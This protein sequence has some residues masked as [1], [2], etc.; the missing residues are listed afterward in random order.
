MALRQVL[1]FILLACSAAIIVYLA[2]FYDWQAGGTSGSQQTVPEPY[3]DRDWSKSDNNAQNIS[4]FVF[5]D[6][7]RN[8][9]YDVGDPPMA[10]VTVELTRPDGSTRRHAS[11]INGYTNFSMHDGSDNHDITTVD[12][13]YRFDLLIPPG[14]KVT[15]TNQRQYTVFTRRQGSA[16]GIVAAS[17]PTVIGL[18]PDLY[19]QSRIKNYQPHSHSLLAT[20]PQGDSTEVVISQSGSFSHPAYPGEWLLTLRKTNNPG[21]LEQRVSV[22]ETPVIL[23]DFDGT[24]KQPSPNNRVVVQDFEYQNRS[25]IDKIPMG[26]LGLGWDFL[27]A[28]DNQFYNGPGYVNVLQDG[29]MVGYNSSGHPVTITSYEPGTSFDFVGAY[30]GVAWPAAEGESLQ[31]KAWRGSELIAEDTVKLS[32]LGAVWFQADYR[33]ITRLQLT[34][35]HY[36]QFVTEHMRFRLPAQVTAQKPPIVL[37]GIPDLGQKNLGI[38]LAD[39]GENYCGA[40]AA[41]NTLA[42][43]QGDTDPELQ[44]SLIHLLAGKGFMHVNADAGV[45][46]RNFLAGM[47]RY[48]EQYLGAYR[49]LEYAGW[50]RGA[51]SKRVANRPSLQWLASGLHQ[52]AGVW[53]N[54]GWYESEGNSFRRRGGH[55]LTLVGLED[56]Q[57]LIHDP[58]PWAG[59]RPQLHR[60]GFSRLQ[61]GWLQSKT[62]TDLPISAEGYLLLDK[63]L[64]LPRSSYQAILDGAVLLELAERV[65][66]TG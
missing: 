49:R 1:G 11:N 36:W 13:N 31:I 57:L 19:I 21:S 45:G 35:E 50:R 52:R 5:R 29:T 30:F 18:A 48:V 6:R 12:E 56:N 55:W 2:L 27:L 37:N 66:P 44:K 14:W 26:N 20:S 62:S 8:G 59:D 64:K 33:D 53:L 54:I 17:P 39:D 47:E 22:T 24:E 63:E 7:N 58:G 65:R 40:V 10:S 9:V 25:F 60:V 16:A 41:S 32:F 28:I 23:A 4:V 42:W 61:Q 51:E 3:A 43:L 46:P 15:T 34:S 38:N